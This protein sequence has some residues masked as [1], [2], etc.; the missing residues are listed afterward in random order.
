MRTVI[1]AAVLALVV[2]LFVSSVRAGE[3]KKAEAVTVQGVLACQMKDN[4]C[5]GHVL[6][7]A[8]GVKYAVTGDKCKDLCKLNGKT[9]KVTGVVSEKDGAKSIAAEKVEE[10]VA[11]PAE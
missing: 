7:A 4:A 10:V 9:V 2:G 8:D 3:E 11:A 5:T 1:L 6:T